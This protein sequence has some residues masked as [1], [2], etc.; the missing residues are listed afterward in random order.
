MISTGFHY[1]RVWDYIT[2]YV[3]RLSPIRAL[4]GLDVTSPIETSALPL[5]AEP[6]LAWSAWSGPARS[7]NRKISGRS[8]IL[9][10]GAWSTTA[11]RTCRR[12]SMSVSGWVST[13]SE[14]AV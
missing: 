11:R 3:P 14:Y 5:H 13:L 10:S 4:T 8:G 12:A 6:P 1:A 9:K 2:I 7:D